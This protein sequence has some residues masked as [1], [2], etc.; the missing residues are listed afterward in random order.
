MSSVM[1][2]ENAT[3]GSWAYN[4]ISQIVRLCLKPMQIWESIFHCHYQ[5][6]DHMDTS[7]VTMPFM[8][9]QD[10]FLGQNFQRREETKF[11]T[12]AL[13]FFWDRPGL[14]NHIWGYCSLESLQYQHSNPWNLYQEFP[15]NHQSKPNTILTP[16]C[17]T[18]LFE[19]MATGLDFK[20]SS[21]K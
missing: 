15:S 19:G 5:I 9:F 11:C 21:L 16:C 4:S 1:M 13:W 8:L 10:A 17:L 7:V 14:Y 18:S 2:T 12:R 6:L 20:T 3:I